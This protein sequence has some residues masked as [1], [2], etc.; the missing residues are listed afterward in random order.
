VP[1]WSQVL[2]ARLRATWQ[3]LRALPAARS[4]PPEQHVHP[5]SIQAPAE[6]AQVSV[7]ASDAQVAI[8]LQGGIWVT[9]QQQDGLVP[10]LSNEDFI[11]WLAQERQAFEDQVDKD[12]EAWRRSAGLSLDY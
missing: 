10:Y 5:A 6:A 3:R 1:S 12:V 7:V 8:T 4:N 2:M 9:S 11:T